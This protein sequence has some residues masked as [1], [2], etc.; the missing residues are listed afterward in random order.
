MAR[1]ASFS[2]GAPAP[3]LS[4][5]LPM[6]RLQTS[7]PPVPALSASRGEAPS[8]R[9]GCA[10]QGIDRAASM[11][12][13]MLFDAGAADPEVAPE[14]LDLDPVA[15]IDHREK[16]FDSDSSG[17]DASDPANVYVRCAHGTARPFVPQGSTR[18]A[19]G[20]HAFFLPEK[21]LGRRRDFFRGFR[22]PDCAPYV[23]RMS[24]G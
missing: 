15:E 10:S 3:W 4:G 21:I 22:I 16:R 17:D 18:A 1:V 24:N 19:R 23:W 8:P 14:A 12:F 7:G 9:R 6:M 2:G 5:A 20:R 13:D 11:D